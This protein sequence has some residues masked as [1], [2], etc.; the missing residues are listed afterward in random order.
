M[1]QDQPIIFGADDRL[2]SD[3]VCGSLFPEEHSKTE[4]SPFGSI[5][6]TDD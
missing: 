3:R 4:R 5:G 1:S 6:S 2:P